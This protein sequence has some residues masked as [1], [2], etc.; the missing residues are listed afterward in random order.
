MTL[1]GLTEAARLTGKDKATIHRAMKSGRLSFTVGDDGDRQID[2]AELERVYSIK[3]Q[4]GEP[5]VAPRNRK[6]AKSN[7]VQIAQLAA[8]LEIEH[9][10]TVSL[11][12][13]LADKDSV[14]DDLR[15]RLDREGEERRQAQARLTALLTDQRRKVPP[16]VIAM[17]SPP[18][19]AGP[20][21][22]QDSPPVS[23]APPAVAPAQLVS[24]AAEGEAAPRHVSPAATA[25]DGATP[26][27]AADT[28]NREQRHLPQQVVKPPA[29]ADVAW[30]RKMMGGK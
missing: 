15:R 25:M 19:S 23:L 22:Q 26:A 11:E 18:T 16:D 3:P 10:K 6:K 30:W 7:H 2:P 29:K 12:E 24:T 13:R 4:D 8:Q 9:A 1:I 20:I 14:I 17:P 5:E 27:P 21:A 28:D